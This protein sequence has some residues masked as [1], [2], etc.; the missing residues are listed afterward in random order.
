MERI[1]R[2]NYYLEVA[3]SVALRSTCLISKYG[4]VIVKNDAIVSTGY[5]GSARG[6]KNCIEVGICIRDF[7]GFSRYNDCRA[8]HSEANALLHAKYEDLIGSTAYIARVDTT[9]SS[10]AIIEPC[11]SCK[12]LLINAQLSKVICLQ[13]DKSIKEFKV[14][15]WIE[16]V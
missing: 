9:K 3:K 12:R 8:V 14:T 16:S 13:D 6:A 2:I 4:C 1:S 10:H 5:N 11:K 15:D 7:E